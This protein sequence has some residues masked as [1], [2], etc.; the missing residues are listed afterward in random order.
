MTLEE[1]LVWKDKFS[2][3]LE[4]QGISTGPQKYMFTECLQTCGG[5]D[6]FTQATLDIGRWTV[7]NFNKVLPEITKHSLPS[8]SFCKQEEYFCSHLIKPRHMKLYNFNISIL[9][10]LNTYL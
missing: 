6:I 9:Q 8:Y 1:G 10:E 7:E 5:K 4:D 2:E 3:A